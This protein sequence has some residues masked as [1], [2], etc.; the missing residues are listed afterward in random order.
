MTASRLRLSHP[1]AAS[2]I[3]ICSD[4]TGTLT[5]NK[6][7]VVQ[8]S[9]AEAVFRNPQDAATLNRALPASIRATIVDGLAVNSTAYEGKDDK[10]KV[11]RTCQW[12]TVVGR[13]R[14]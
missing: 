9:I 2:R 12:V 10:G 3:A 1:V 8:G 6:M 7:T 4:K 14:C 5:Q 13:A 11:V